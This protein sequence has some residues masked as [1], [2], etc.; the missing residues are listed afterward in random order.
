MKKTCVLIIKVTIII[1]LVLL[2]IIGITILIGA[3]Q[4]KPP[5]HPLDFQD[6]GRTVLEKPINS[7]EDGLPYAFNRAYEWRQD[8][9]LTEY[10][11]ISIGEEELKGKNGKFRYIFQFPY[12]N[13]SKPSGIMFISI[14]TN[15]NSIEF[16]SA[17]H[18][19]QAGTRSFSKLNLGNLTESIK[20]VYDVAIKHI[21]EENIY[22]YEQ[23]F[24]R[25]YVNSNFAR[26][27]VSPSQSEPNI[28][29]YRV[30][31]DMKT[32]EILTTNE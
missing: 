31:I 1:L 17:S 18:D 7:V 16:V 12:I 9:V 20:K 32:F 3:L 14:N 27:E 11:I 4:E 24:V 8:V 15:T 25:V 19:G 26:F 29:E 5:E 6:T 2:F 30:K 28:I 23:P 10:Q 13:E 21:G 22:Q